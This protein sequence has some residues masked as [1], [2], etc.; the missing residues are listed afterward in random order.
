MKSILLFQ[1]SLPT[2]D[3]PSLLG[4]ILSIIITTIITIFPNNDTLVALAGRYTTTLYIMH[5]Q[6]H[7]YNTCMFC[8][9]NIFPCYRASVTEMAGRMPDWGRGHSLSR[10]QSLQNV[11]AGSGSAPTGNRSGD[12]SLQPAP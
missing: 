4:Q 3:Y 5:F 10:S 9:N 1:N 6:A 7:H 2:L 12:F 11:G 8:L